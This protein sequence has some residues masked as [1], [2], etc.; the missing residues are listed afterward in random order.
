[1]TKVKLFDETELIITTQQAEALKAALNRSTEGFVTVNGQT[2]KK[3]AISSIT[4]G[5]ITEDD[6]PNFN[7]RAIPSGKVC[8]GKFSINTEINRI[9]QDE[10]GKDWANLIRNTKWREETRQK[11]KSIPGTLWCDYREGS[12]HCG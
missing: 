7:L 12:C 10:G 3:N 5:G 8:T 11:L 2:I 9:A 4:T 6:L 1:M